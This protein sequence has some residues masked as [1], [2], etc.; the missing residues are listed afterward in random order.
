MN[1]GRGVRPT[2]RNP[3]PVQ[4]TKD[5][6][7]ATLS[8]RKCWN[9]LPCS[10]LDQAGRI[11][12]SKNG[13]YFHAFPRRCTKSAKI[14]WSKGETTL[15]KTRICEIVYPVYDR[16]LSQTLSQAP[17]RVIVSP[18]ILYYWGQARS[19]RE[20]AKPGLHRNFS[21]VDFFLCGRSKILQFLLPF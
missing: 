18:V 15:F 21:I 8:E 11:Q 16:T 3:D 19:Q 20:A 9:F 12:N 13:T 7:F 1:L 10:R 14:M 6:N 2:Q 4:D 17:Q 5:V